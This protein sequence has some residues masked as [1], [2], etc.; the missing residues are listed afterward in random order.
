MKRHLAII[1][2]A[3]VLAA[4]AI[5]ATAPKRLSISH[6]AES[7]KSAAP[8]DSSR[9]ADLTI[10]KD[11]EP[12]QA[13]AMVSVGYHFNN[14]WFAVKA[15]N[16]PL[17]DF[18]LN[19]TKSHMRWSVRIIPVRKDKSGADVKL[20]DILQAIESTLVK[21]LQESVKAQDED[22]FVNAYKVMLGQGCYSCHK[23]SDK[24]Y[25][26]PQIPTQPAESIINFDPNA[27]WPL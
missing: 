15:K 25:L 20:N 9:D 21:E 5:S 26:R 8:T 4:I 1:A 2:C 10:L 27:A 3:L 6:A 17:A 24:P 11:R 23:A 7:G 12:D 16:W 18:Y 19:E 13:H 22:R 14:L